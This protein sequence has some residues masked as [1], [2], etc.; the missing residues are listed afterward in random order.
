MNT[1]DPSGYGL[2]SDKK[3]HTIEPPR[4]H[5]LPQIPK[6]LSVPIALIGTGGISEYHLQAYQELGLNVVALC[7]RNLDAAISRRDQYY[8]DAAVY[9]DYREL[10]DKHEIK[11]ADITTHPSV[12]TE[13]IEA[14]LIR[15]IH[16]LSQKPFVTDLADGHHLRALAKKH[17]AM[18]AVNQNGRWA[19]HFSYMRNAIASGLIGDVVSVDFSLQWD[20]TWIAGIPAFESMH[21]MVLFDFAIHWFDIL[22]TFMQGNDPT[23]VYAVA[24]K[25]PI[26][27]YQPPA[28]AS[29]S[30]AYPHAV[31]SMSLNAHTQLG[32][33]DTTTIVGTQG[34]LRSRGPGLNDQPEM[35]LYL[36]EGQTQVSLQGSWFTHGFQGTMCELLCAIE[37]NREPS[38]HA[39]SSMKALE[40]CFAAVKSAESGQ[41]VSP[42]DVTRLSQF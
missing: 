19:P 20:Q 5:Y 18:L 38:N 23:M 40:L 35:E 15:G 2:S 21:H 10:F 28:L 25:S 3:S 13:I 30:I 1:D 26:Q 22:G 33:E 29:V 32:E 27:T 6:D 4:I 14:A 31:A 16:V 34:T 39:E 37:E 11:V 12:R 41:A 42:G 36:P 8:P 9:T 7:D 17:H 24:R